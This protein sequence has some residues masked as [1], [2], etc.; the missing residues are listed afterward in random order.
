MQRHFVGWEDSEA[1]TDQIWTGS[2]SLVSPIPDAE[3]DRAIVMG[4]TDDGFP[5]VGNIPGKQGQ[6]ICAGFNGHGMPQAFLSAKAV[7]SMIADGTKPE[8]TD[9]P[10]LYRFTQ[11]R[12]TS[13]EEHHSVKAYN[14]V[15]QTLGLQN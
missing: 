2:E 8:D 12:Y 9:L 6:Y 13:K 7:A 11:E 1:Y 10:R 15:M 3:A 4:Y 14:A 5:Y